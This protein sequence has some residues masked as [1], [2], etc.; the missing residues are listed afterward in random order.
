[1]INNVEIIAYK[2]ELFENPIID[3]I[4]QE[5]SVERDRSITWLLQLCHKQTQLRSMQIWNLI[6]KY[7]P[8]RANTLWKQKRLVHINRFLIL[9]C[10]FTHHFLRYMRQFVGFFVFLLCILTSSIICMV[11]SHS[12][13]WLLFSN[14]NI[15]KNWSTETKQFA[16]TVSEVEIMSVP[17]LTS[18]HIITDKCPAK[19]KI[20]HFDLF[21]TFSHGFLLLFLIKGELIF[22]F[23]VLY[24]TLLH[25]PP[26]R[27]NCVGPK[28]LGSNPGQM[29]LCNW[30]SDALSTQL[31][32]IFF[33]CI[34]EVIWGTSKNQIKMEIFL[35]FTLFY[36]L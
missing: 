35:D 18:C 29:R 6:S 23:I 20:K 21:G 8:H 28:I 31:N 30:Q 33:E 11:S 17:I 26:L 25:L 4:N 19:I 7:Q 9:S 22:F 13:L 36:L 2:L 1:M 34:Y 32:L 12:I 16:S 10:F 14:I 5:I 15:E 24:S 3:F 27:L